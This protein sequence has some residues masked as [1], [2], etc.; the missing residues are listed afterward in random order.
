MTILWTNTLFISVM[1]AYYILNDGAWHILSV[2]LVYFKFIFDV[3]ETDPKSKAFFFL[4][5]LRACL[6][7]VKC[8]LLPLQDQESLPLAF[9]FLV[10]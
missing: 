4:Q 9:D 10:F 6:T 2:N 5:Q 7:E 8:N 3:S 1:Y